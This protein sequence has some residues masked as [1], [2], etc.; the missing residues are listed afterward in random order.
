MAV[1]QNAPTLTRP[2]CLGSAG[3]PV[4]ALQAFL[5]GAGMALGPPVPVD[6]RFARSTHVAVV[7]FQ[8]RKGLKPDGVVGRKTAEAIGWHYTPVNE[9]PYTIS[10]ESPSLPAVTPPLAVV[11]EAIRIGMAQ[12]A[13]KIVDDF[14]DA[15]TYPESDPQF[16]E[17]MG[18]VYSEQPDLSKKQ[19]RQR[20]LRIQDV[21]FHYRR[22]MKALGEMV[23]L[24]MTDPQSVPKKLREAFSEFANQVITACN[25]VDFYYGNTQRCRKRVHDFRYDSIVGTVGSL[26]SGDRTVTFAVAQVQIVFQSMAYFNQLNGFNSVD[27][28]SL[29]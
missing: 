13:E 12:F 10:Y 6:G 4:R 27:R 8:R 24:S 17:F 14:W 5:N 28:P 3:P 25:G 23:E 20:T 7:L 19:F 18:R 9:K 11:A 16:R 22:F 2:L 15:Y 21:I 26:L 29:E 1:P